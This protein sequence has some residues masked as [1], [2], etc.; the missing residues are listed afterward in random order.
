MGK[1]QE[2]FKRIDFKDGKFILPLILLLPTLFVGYML[3]DIFRSPTGE[4]IVEEDNQELAGV[5]LAD[6]L[7]IQSKDEAIA[8]FIGKKEDYTAIKIAEEMTRIDAD[9]TIYTEAE[10][11][12]IAQLERESKEAEERVRRTNE[13]IRSQNEQLSFNR[14]QLAND[15][16][17]N[18]DA[19]SKEIQM[20][21]KIL[22]GEEL[23][24]P[25]EEQR[26][27]IE[28]I[29][30]EER[31][32]VMEEINNKET[33]LIE[34]ISTGNK[35]PA[36]N[37]I[38]TEKEENNYI[39]AMVDQGVTVTDGSRI[40]FRLLDDIKIQGQLVPAGTLIYA[41][42]SG[43]GEQRV[44]ANVSSII[45]KGKRV[46]VNLS[47]FDQ[48]GIEGF[49]IPKSTFRDLGREA[50]SQVA[51]S[52]SITLETPSNN[53]GGMA[54]QALQNA[55]QSVSSAVSK[56]IRENK[57]KIKYNTTVYLINNE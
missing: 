46:K 31:Q 7:A 2:P 37:T 55:Y 44:M 14:R 11:E 34:K 41:L 26:R 21:Q 38:A 3:I 39:R 32:R 9:T 22:N 30:Q 16:S 47:V 53:L 51:N 56:K 13:E 42:V 17:T 40:T 45:T 12:Y 4:P 35:A 33:V 28:R 15:I 19:L 23:L 48:D 52:G 50:G 8:E 5:P 24:T 29:R 10:L 18:D 27:E 25:E 43:F 1:F 49:F 54:V 20:Y 57:A 36:F 6:S